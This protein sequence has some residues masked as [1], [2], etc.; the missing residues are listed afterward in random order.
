MITLE[1]L[2]EDLINSKVP[3]SAIL[4]EAYALAH[5]LQDPS[6]LDWVKN[7]LFGY[8]LKQWE[9]RN[10][11]PT[12]RRPAGYLKATGPYN[13]TNP[14]QIP[15]KEFEDKIC[16]PWLPYSV[17][18][19]EAMIAERRQGE[20]II[21]LVNSQNAAILRKA[22][23]LTN[24]EPFLEYTSSDFVAILET[25]QNMLLALVLDLQRKFP[26]LKIDELTKP[27][28]QDIA[29][30]VLQVINNPTSC[31]I[32]GSQSIPITFGQFEEIIK[33]QLQGQSIDPERVKE[34]VEIL[35]QGRGDEEARMKKSLPKKVAE[36]LDKNKSWITEIVIEAIKIY[37]TGSS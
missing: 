5:Q 14:I 26:D 1:K 22:V 13:I 31:I 27:E 8:D 36:Y 20:N 19:I 23:G 12:Y 4:R 28:K 35:K 15:N 25:V 24:I 6:F 10:D 9:E 37:F 34:L 30:S 7:E 33:T 29:A 16:R 21:I 11:F 17:G 32:S 18:K 3:L 2:C